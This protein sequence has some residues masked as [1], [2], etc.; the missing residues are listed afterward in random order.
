MMGWDSGGM[1]PLGWLAAGVFWSILLALVVWLVSRLLPASSSAT[2]GPIDELALE[3][4]DDQ[5]VAG[6][7]DMAAWQ[8]QRSARTTA[9]GSATGRPKDVR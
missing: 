6:E 8:A 9:A 3:A 2:T 1:A 7:I 5:L 4:L